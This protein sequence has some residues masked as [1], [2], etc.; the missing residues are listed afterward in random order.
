MSTFLIFSQRVASRNR[1]NNNRATDQLDW[2]A[3]AGHELQ[4]KNH[5]HVHLF[6]HHVAQLHFSIRVN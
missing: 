5:R 2:L 6:L 1:S 4:V 3:M